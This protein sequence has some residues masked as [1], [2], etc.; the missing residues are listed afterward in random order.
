MRTGDPRRRVKRFVPQRLV[1]PVLIRA[2][3][4]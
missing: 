2:L 3:G 1:E 4:L